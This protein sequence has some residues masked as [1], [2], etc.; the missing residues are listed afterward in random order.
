MNSAL[1]TL[2]IR[3]LRGLS[4]QDQDRALCRM[5]ND[6]LCEIG[7]ALGQRLPT[8]G[9]DKPVLIIGLLQRS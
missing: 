2:T 5:H 8:I 7:L 9:G 6:D 1:I 3:N 4:I